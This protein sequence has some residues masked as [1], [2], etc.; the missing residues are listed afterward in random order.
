MEF[1]E[2]INKIAKSSTVS[3][4]VVNLDEQQWEYIVVFGAGSYGEY[5]GRNLISLGYDISFYIDNNDKVWGQELLNIP[6]ISPVNLT[7]MYTSRTLVIICSTWYQE[8]ELQL[9]ELGITNIVVINYDEYY[10]MFYIHSKSQQVFEKYFIAETTKF[11]KLHDMLSDEKSK[12]VLKHLL[13][14]RISGNPACLIK[15]EFPQYFHPQVSPSKGD[16]IIDGGG[17]IGDTVKQF[18]D[19]LD[20]QCEIHSFEPSYNNYAQMERLIGS[21]KWN[22]VIPVKAGIGEK[23]EI[24]YM[25]PVKDSVDP[26]NSI[27]LTGE[28]ETQVVSLDEY[29]KENNLETVDFI[30]M[31]IEGFEL[32]AL[33]GASETIRKFKPKLQI[34]LYHKNEDM[35]VIPALLRDLLSDTGYK[36]Y[37]GHHSESALETV[38]YAICE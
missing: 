19:Y 34:C 33:K 29:V 16:T 18:N 14:Y 5:V 25:N 32:Y 9:K 17:F 12:E 6:I 21:E 24:L 37:I 30:K 10:Q 15:S 7:E 4:L 26:G 3:N 27:S 38:L 1:I 2:E 31:D 20:S 8:I 22:N 28:V 23:N 13:A 11:E 35:V 36:Y